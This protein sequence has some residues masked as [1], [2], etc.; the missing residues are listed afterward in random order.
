MSYLFGTVIWQTFILR[1]ITLQINL[2][3]A[4]YEAW[5]KDAKVAAIIIKGTGGKV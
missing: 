2:L 3:R 1:S 4:Q 5:N